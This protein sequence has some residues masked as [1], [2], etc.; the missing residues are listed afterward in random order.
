MSGNWNFLSM[1]TSSTGH[2]GISKLGKD[3]I[4]GILLYFCIVILNL[5]VATSSAI[6]QE[7]RPKTL[8]EAHGNHPF[9]D[10]E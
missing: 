1:P 9:P 6:A 4:G 10:I 8:G 7:H 5:R 2:V 3:S